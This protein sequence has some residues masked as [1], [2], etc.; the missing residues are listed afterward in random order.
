MPR[1]LWLC[2][3]PPPPPPPLARPLP[4][5]SPSLTRQRRKQPRPTAITGHVQA[6]GR[7]AQTAA[8][9]MDFILYLGRRPA[10][11]EEAA[12]SAASDRSDA[13][14]DSD[15]LTVSTCL[16]LDVSVRACDSWSV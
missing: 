14:Q 1:S 3:D 7:A 6:H 2:L 15:S 5:D 11:R 10:R 12:K 4:S 8:V 16:E 13:N 9:K